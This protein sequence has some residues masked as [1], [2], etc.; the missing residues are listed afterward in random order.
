[1]YPS[2]IPCPLGYR[3]SGCLASATATASVAS[4][5]AS[6]GVA[7]TA[8]K[9]AV[10]AVAAGAYIGHGEARCGL[11]PCCCPGEGP[12]LS[13]RTRGR[14]SSSQ[15]H[16]PGPGRVILTFLSAGSWAA[17]NLR[18]ALPTE[19]LTK[20]RAV[21]GGDGYSSRRRRGRQLTHKTAGPRVTVFLQREPE[22]SPRG[23]F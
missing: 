14:S 3:A 15:H 11:Q 23:G 21:S 10:V 6:S 1:M 16:R 13:A 20:S 19:E 4:S 17:H 8:T 18:R 7:T 5:S 9:S 12:P 22:S 2:G